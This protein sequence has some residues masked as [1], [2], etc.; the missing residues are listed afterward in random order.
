MKMPSTLLGFDLNTM[1]Y[2]PERYPL[3][4][5]SF[6]YILS[7]E[8]VEMCLKEGVQ[9]VELG[10]MIAHLCYKFEKF[11]KRISKLLLHGISRGDFEKVKSYLDV[12]TQ[13]A[14]IKDEFQQSRLEWLFGVGILNSFTALKTDDQN[15]V[16]T[17]VGIPALHSMS[18]ETYS[19]K[20]ALIQDSIDDSLL[21]LLW[22]YKGR[23][24]TYTVNCLYGL[25]NLISLDE[26]V[27]EFFAKLPSP[28]YVY[29]RY[30]DWFLPYL[31][32]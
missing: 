7:S 10:R 13:L 1:K 2:Q 15:E 5:E 25:L 23:M 12:V 22:R 8:F 21:H 31:E 20:S 9:C 27:A 28:T 30:T 3:K 19:F 29:A 11:S 24:D 14:I 26:Y 4:D 18:D 16:I 17:K 6:D 32:K